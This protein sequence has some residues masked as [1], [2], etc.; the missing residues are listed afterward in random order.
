M[1]LVQEAEREGFGAVIVGCFYDVGPQAPREL[2]ES[3]L[4]VA[5]CEASVHLAARLGDRFSIIVGRAK[6]VPEMRK[7][8]VR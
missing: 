2:S 6:W 1:H 3:M 7:N 8:V 5:A 4:V